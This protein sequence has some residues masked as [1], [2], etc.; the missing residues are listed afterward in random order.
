MQIHIIIVER[1]ERFFFFFLIN[2]KKF[3]LKVAQVQ[4]MSYNLISVSS[5]HKMGWR[6]GHGLKTHCVLV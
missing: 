5:S 2:K 1:F 6:W 3:I 4:L